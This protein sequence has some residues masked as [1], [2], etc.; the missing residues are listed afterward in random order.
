MVEINQINRSVSS[1][2][3]QSDLIFYESDYGILFH[4]FIHVAVAVAVA[5][6]LMI[7][8]CVLSVINESISQK[9]TLFTV[10]SVLFCLLFFFILFGCD[11]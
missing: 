1:Y 2:Q 10:S 7:L 4:G 5:L 6:G 11:Q 9:S 8:K 3:Y